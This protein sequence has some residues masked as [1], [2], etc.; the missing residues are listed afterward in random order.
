MPLEAT[1]LREQQA[2]PGGQNATHANA[3]RTTVKDDEPEQ[4]VQLIANAGFRHEIA[5]NTVRTYTAQWRRYAMWARAKGMVILPAGPSQ[6]AS[7]IEQCAQT[8]GYKPATLRTVAAA[9]AF[10]QSGERY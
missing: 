4:S 5:M 8:L 3:R 1:G 9:I 2:D 10:V 6:I 7:Y